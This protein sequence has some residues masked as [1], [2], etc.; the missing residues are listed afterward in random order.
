MIQDLERFYLPQVSRKCRKQNASRLQKSFLPLGFDS[1]TLLL[2]SSLV[3]SSFS[4]VQNKLSL[5]FFSLF[6]A[7]LAEPQWQAKPKIFPNI[8][9]KF[10]LST[11]INCH[12]YLFVLSSHQHVF[13]YIKRSTLVSHLSKTF[14]TCP[15]FP[16]RWPANKVK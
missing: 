13:H 15:L 14:C 2:P 7:G 8:S 10:H 3:S 6:S 11:L 12:H 1:K 16:P 9:S 5:F 4:L